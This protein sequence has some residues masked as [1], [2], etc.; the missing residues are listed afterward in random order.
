VLI[1]DITK[2]GVILKIAKIE[3]CNGYN[4]SVVIGDGL[5]YAESM[6]KHAYVHDEE[7]IK[8]ELLN[9]DFS[10]L[11]LDGL[12]CRWDKIKPPAN[13]LEVV[14]LLIEATDESTQL[15][16][17]RDVLIKLD[18][19]YGEEEQRHP[20]T[21][22]RLQL[23]TSF[24]KFSKE[25]RARYAKWNGKHFLRSLYES[26][27]GRLY[28]KYNFKVNNLKGKEY[29]EQVIAFSDTL[30]I[31]GRINTIVSGTAENR[32]RLLEYLQQQEQMGVLVYGHHVSPESIM[33]CYIENRDSKHIHF[34]DGANGGYTEAAKELKPK[35]KNL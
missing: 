28:F 34:I 31:D 15:K 1:D 20:I 17:Y 2:A 8:Q 18:E 23:V 27:A 11:N 9:D 12:E 35:L 26:I 22:S 33:T 29:L 4:K 19:I 3:V 10:E 14:C 21:L 32:K 16:V 5:K 7:K 30:T 6:I 13:Q 24:K 25:V